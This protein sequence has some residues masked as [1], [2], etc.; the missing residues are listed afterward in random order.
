MA[1]ETPAWEGIAKAKRE[2]VLGLIPEKWRIQSPIPPASELRDVTVY[3]QKF[4][5]PREIEITELDTVSLAERTTTGQ[6]TAVEVTEAFCHR[7]ALAHQFVSCLHE[8]FFDSAIEDAKRLDAY[9]AENKKPIGPL[10]GLPISLKDQFHVKG[11]ET[12]MGYVSWIGTFQ[13]LKGD[14]RRLTFESVLVGELRALGAVLHCKT[15]V[16]ATLMSGETFNHIIDYTYNP[17]NRHLSCGGSSGGEGALIALRGS[18]GG[19]GTD[20][21]GSVRFPAA[22]NGLYGIRPSAGRIPY[23]GA[24]NSMDGQNSILSVIGPLATTVGGLKLLFQSVL[25]QQPWLHDPLAVELPW[26]DALEEETL[27]LVKNSTAGKGQ[28]AFGILYDDGIVRPHPPVARAL[29][30]M[31][32]TV[33][34][35]GH[36]LIQWDP[37]SHAKAL[38]LAAA[39]Y[40]YDGGADAR[41]QFDASGEPFFDEL[42]LFLK[43]SPQSDATQIAA[44]NVAKREYQKSYMEYWNSTAEL[45]GTGRPVDGLFCPTAPFAASRQGKNFY[46][47]YTSFVNVLDYSSIVIPVTLADKTV[48]VKESDFSPLSDQDK[49]THEEYDP[50]IF[51]GAYVGVQL[52]GR[53]FQEEKLLVLADY[54]GAAVKVAE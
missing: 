13:G 45:T 46:V 30:L 31:A 44:T 1:A 27:S 37:P 5:T 24:A 15:S 6:W 41:K 53:R 20:I 43:Q 42:A 28:L 33:Q 25:S 9:F 36:K 34:K 35:L 51:D 7:S 8:I 16:P 14:P 49:I 47:N 38:Q 32:K 22:F 18:A 23:E 54:L 40:A 48:D 10:H 52:V 17:K 11:V 50:E 3:I 39:I 19:F 29:A 21:G 26:R 2:A 4:L 12:T